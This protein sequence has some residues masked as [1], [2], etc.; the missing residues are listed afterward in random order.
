ME[1]RTFRGKGSFTLTIISARLNTRTFVGDEVGACILVMH[2]LE[3]AS[4]ACLGFDQNLVAALDQLAR[5][6]PASYRPGT[7]DP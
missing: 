4:H 2:V 7:P 1:Q 6:L 3:S 5:T